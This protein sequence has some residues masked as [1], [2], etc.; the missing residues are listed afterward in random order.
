MG[1]VHKATITDARR[2]RD[3]LLMTIELKDD[4]DVTIKTVDTSMAF[5][6][7]NPPDAARV[8][9]HVMTTLRRLWKEGLEP[10]IPVP[11]LIGQEV[12]LP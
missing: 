3:C 9:E 12:V 4:A 10:E 7:G 1:L 11:A 2:T 8:R 5:E 6:R